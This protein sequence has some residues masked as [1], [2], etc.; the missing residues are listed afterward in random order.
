MTSLTLEQASIIVD[1]ALAA[2]RELDLRPLSVTVLDPGGHPIVLK[3]EDN[4]G[5][6][7]PEIAHAKAWGC[8]GMGHGGGRIARHAERSPEFFTALTAISDG[9]I[10]SSRGGVL[11]RDAEGALLGAVGVSGDNPDNDEKAALAGIAKAGLVA[12]AG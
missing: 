10:A 5:I 8:L 6:L 4:S 12:D 1:A 9:R 2:G 3:R 11:I 7:R